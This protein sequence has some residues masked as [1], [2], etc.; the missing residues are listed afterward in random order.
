MRVPPSDV[1][2][3]HVLAS[4]EEALKFVFKVQHFSLFTV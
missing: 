2:M 4:R 3:K 1:G